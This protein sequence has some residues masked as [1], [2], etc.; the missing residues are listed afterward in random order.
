MTESGRFRAKYNLFRHPPRSNDSVF[1]VITK[2]QDYFN[3]IGVSHVNEIL[4]L[5]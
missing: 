1:K 2:R 4:H 5:A 3:G